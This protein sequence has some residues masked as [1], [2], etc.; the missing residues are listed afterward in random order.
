MA[1]AARGEEIGE[2][3]LKPLAVRD[4][5]TDKQLA[6]F[7][8]RVLTAAADVRKRRGDVDQRD[9]RQARADDAEYAAGKYVSELLAENVVDAPRSNDDLPSDPRALADLIGR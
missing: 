4:E 5:V 6:G 1:R 2:E 9:G 7:R 8:A 3:D